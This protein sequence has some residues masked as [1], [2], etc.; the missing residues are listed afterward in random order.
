MT[1]LRIYTDGG[2]S[3]NQ[4]SENIGGWGAILEFAGH[5]KELFGGEKNTTNNRMEMTALISAFKAIKKPGQTIE[6][7]SDSSYLMDCFRKKWYVS[8]EKNGWV[9][10]S[11][12]PVENKDLWQELLVYA[13]QHDITCFRVK[14]H[15]NLRGAAVNK[16]ALYAKFTE[17]NGKRFSFDD[18]VYVTE[19]NNR[20]DELANMGIDAQRI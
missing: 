4:S 9:N 10:S 5:R 17:W 7:F 19:M 1:V 11:K 13:R 12:K 18:F 2:C 15:V 14:G 6:I 3:G 16:E 20:A 8:W